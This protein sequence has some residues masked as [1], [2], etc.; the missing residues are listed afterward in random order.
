VPAPSALDERLVGRTLAGRFRVERRLAA[1][2]MG[3][4]FVAE[5]QPLGRQVALKVLD[6]HDADR[7]P[8]FA[9][10]FQREATVVSALQHPNAVV[11]FDF[12]Q[13]EDGLYFYAMELLEG[14][15]LHARVKG[16]GALTPAQAV[17]VGTQVAACLQEAHDRDLVHRDLKPGNV[18]LTRRGQDDLFAKVLDFGLVKAVGPKESTNLTASGV[19]LGSPSYMAPEQV[20]GR[21]VDPRVD[22]YALGATLYFALA[23]QPPFSS[24]NPMEVLQMQVEHEPPALAYLGVDVPPALE[25]VVQRCLTKEPTHRFESMRA[26]EAALRRAVDPH[27]ASDRPRRVVVSSTARGASAAVLPD[28]PT[29]MAVVDPSAVLRPDAPTVEVERRRGGR[30]WVLV[31]AALFLAL[32]ALGVGLGFAM[33]SP[34]EAVAPAAVAPEAVAPAPV[35]LLTEPPGARVLR[36]GRDVGDAPMTLELL[37]GEVR[38]LELE[39]EGHATRTVTVDGE[40]PEVRVRLEPLPAA[41]VP[42]SAEPRWAPTPEPAPRA[43]PQRPAAAAAPARD[44]PRPSHSPIRDPWA[45]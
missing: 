38:E 12:G 44:E 15:T 7:D 22:Q 5:Q 9:R 45:D 39:L 17:H 32:A 35:L 31:A 3:T 13:T 26:V 6:P 40:A 1:G 28:A 27:G 24:S 8:T 11:L 29:V 21:D 20:L 42:P 23:G 4:V 41:A 16:G 25:A 2:G 33:S 37:P 36:D 34:S 10:R 14:P 30:G 43:A 19:V 18:I